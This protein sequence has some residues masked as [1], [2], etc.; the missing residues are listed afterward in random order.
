MITIL[1]YGIGNI[2]SIANMLDY[3]NIS[4]CIASDSRTVL[5]AKKL[6]LPGVGSFDGAMS[7]IMD[8]QDLKETLDHKALY[9]KIP[10][11]GICL[12]MQILTTSSEEG[13]LEGFDWIKAKIKRFSK[14]QGLKVPHMGWND[15]LL[16]KSN[17]L[18]KN[19]PEVQRYYFV[20]SYYVEVED[21]YNSIMKTTYGHQFDSAINLQNIF[22]VQ[23]HPEKSHKYGMNLLKNFANL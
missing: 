13:K 16:D 12:G 3:L 15:A 19:L 11:L 7:R 14:D 17:V 18:L 8:I 9:E 4:F 2:G 5:R 21:P 23:F 1:N 6:I 20:H 10:I 22:G